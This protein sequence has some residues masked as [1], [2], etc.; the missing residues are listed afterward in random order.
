MR[1]N[2]KSEEYSEESVWVQP[3]MQAVVLEAEGIVVWALDGCIL[4]TG[5]PRS[6]QIYM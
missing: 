6:T 1:S 4:W 2:Q 3:R 5:S